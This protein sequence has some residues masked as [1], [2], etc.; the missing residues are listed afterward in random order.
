MIRVSDLIVDY[1]EKGNKFRALNGIDLFIKE[2][3][4]VSIVGRSGS[5]KSTLLSALGGLQYPTSGLVLVDEKNIYECN[6][7]QLADYR[8]KKIGFI[9][10]A[11]HLEEL[12]TSYQN[13]EICLMI[14]QFPKKERKKHI[15]D[16]L[17]KVGMEDKSDIQVGKL[18]GGEKQRICIARAIAN[19]PDIILADEPCGNLDSYNGEIVMNLLQMLANEGKTVILVT[20]N[21]DDALK[22]ERVIELRDGKVVKDEYNG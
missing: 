15:M 12:Y 6:K 22:T 7:N 9:F 17:A 14:S 4:F 16:L 3:T 13:I 20:H 5:G 11:F 18:S 10:Q 8:C 19:N 2:N 21:I 1:N